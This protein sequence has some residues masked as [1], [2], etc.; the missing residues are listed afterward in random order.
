[1]LFTVG[2]FGKSAFNDPDIDI[3]LGGC[4]GLKSSNGREPELQLRIISLDQICRIRYAQTRVFQV[5][6]EIL[7]ALSEISH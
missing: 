1:M 5:A 4:F 6:Q 7:S 2:E 3:I